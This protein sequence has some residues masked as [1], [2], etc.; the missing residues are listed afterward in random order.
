VKEGE[1]LS[2][3]LSMPVKDA[4]G[5]DIDVNYESDI[6]NVQEILQATISRKQLFSDSVD[7]QKLTLE[8]VTHIHVYEQDATQAVSVRSLPECLLIGVDK[9]HPISD[10]RRTRAP[11]RFDPQ[12]MSL[13]RSMSRGPARSTKCYMEAKHHPKAIRW[14]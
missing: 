8:Q 13:S 12:Q 1:K 5:R 7:L 14:L 10:A 3:L 11:S 4:M 2:D 9:G 6:L